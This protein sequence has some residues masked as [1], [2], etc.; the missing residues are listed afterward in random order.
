VAELSCPV[1]LLG[2]V[3]VSDRI[4]LPNLSR[5][6]GAR[7]RREFVDAETGE[8]APREDQVK[9][10]ETESGEFVEFEPEEIAAL[11]PDSDKTLCADRFVPLAD[12]DLMF[13]DRPYFIAPAFGGGGGLPPRPRRACGGKGRGPGACGAVPA[14]APRADPAGGRRPDRH[15]AGLRP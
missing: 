10:Y 9:G 8:A 14:A 1:A 13:L 3:A 4:V 11:V 15:D 6:S 7:L 5:V 2:A 12:V